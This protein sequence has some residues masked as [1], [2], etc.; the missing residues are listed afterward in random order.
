MHLVRMF[1]FVEAFEPNYSLLECFYRNVPGTNVKRHPYALG[2]T[3]GFISLRR[4]DG[5]T[6]HTM[7]TGVEKVRKN[8]D[9][10]HEVA[11]RTIA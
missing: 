8:A 6:D 9:D 2:P 7:N 5:N 1:S 4:F 11:V 3:E 10:A